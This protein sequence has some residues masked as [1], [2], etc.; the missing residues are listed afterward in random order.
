MTAGR[1]T[2]YWSRDGDRRPDGVVRW[3]GDRR[4]R[5]GDRGRIARTGRHPGRLD[6]RRP[7]GEWRGSRGPER[8]GTP[9]RPSE[10][11]DREHLRRPGRCRPGPTRR[12]GLRAR[13]SPGRTR[14]AR[15]SPPSTRSRSSTKR[16][17]ACPP[18]PRRRSSS[19][20]ST[21]SRSR[22]SPG[23]T[24]DSRSSSP[25][26]S[27]AGCRPTRR[28]RARPRSHHSPRM[29]STA[30]WAGINDA[31]PRHA[32]GARDGRRIGSRPDQDPATRV[33]D[34]RRGDDGGR[35][36]LRRRGP[37]SPRGRGSV[38]RQHHVVEGAGPRPSG[39]R[40]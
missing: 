17:Y 32:Q 31:A 35:R 33:C 15:T 37:Q 34:R 23:M 16:R 39:Y 25:P 1:S 36:L 8:A 11:V 14:G 3:P 24:A 18:A 27:V 20:F 19:P 38:R 9:A 26:G 4:G 30:V 10:I 6:P 21:A 40:R 28:R 7:R 22:T 29:T 13:P 2:D 5:V 12:D